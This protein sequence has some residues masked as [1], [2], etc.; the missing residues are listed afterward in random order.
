MSVNISGE[1]S[2]L[3]GLSRQQ[4]LKLW[5]ELY[6]RAAPLGMRRETLLAFLAYRI[7][8][9]ALGGMKPAMRAQLSRVAQ[10]FDRKP[11]GQAR[12]GPLLKAGTRLIR[13]W[14]G[15]GHEVFVTDGGYEYQGTS[16]QSLSEIARKI[17]GTRWSGPTFFGLKKRGRGGTANG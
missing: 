6:G 2:K 17:T 8:E 7:Q 1:L 10:T 5:Q 9:N 13:K 4:L 11:S 14:R 12:A 3:Q 15:N 16:Y